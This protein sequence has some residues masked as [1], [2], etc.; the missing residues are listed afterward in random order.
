MATAAIKKLTLKHFRAT[1]CIEKKK[2]ISINLLE[3]LTIIVT[4]AGAIEALKAH[5]ESV[6][7]LKIGV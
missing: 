1:L 3:Y 7:T 5:K 4:F 2:F 6:E